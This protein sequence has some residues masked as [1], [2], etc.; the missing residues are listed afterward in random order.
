MLFAKNCCMYF[1]CFMCILFC[2]HGNLRDSHFYYLMLQRRKLWVKK[3]NIFPK[4]TQLAVEPGFEPEFFWTCIFNCY[5][6]DRSSKY[7]LHIRIISFLLKKQILKP[8]LR[9]TDPDWVES[10]E[11]QGLLTLFENHWNV[12]S[13]LSSRWWKPSPI[14]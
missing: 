1:A 13:Y 14:I 9:P 6:D 11:I 5:D 2:S 10:S 4:V 8:H 12:L 3:L 7:D